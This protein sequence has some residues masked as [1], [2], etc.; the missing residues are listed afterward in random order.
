MIKETK[1]SDGN[2]QLDALLTIPLLENIND[3]TE[4]ER[5][6]ELDNNVQGLLGYVV[7][8]VN[9]GVGCSKVPDINNVGRMEDRATL[10]ISSQ[11]ICNWLHH[12]LLSAEQVMQTLKRMAV[13]VDTQNEQDNSYIAMAPNFGS[14]LAFK[15]AVDLIFKGQEQPSGYTEPLLHKMRH[16]LKRSLA[17]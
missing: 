14:S 11:H 15:A 8:W 5:Q 6:E 1:V 12:G 17:N 16:E 13:V 3:L 10:R 9:Q 7:R 4:Q 2:T